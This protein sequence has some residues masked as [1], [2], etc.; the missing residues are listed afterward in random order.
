[1]IDR[2]E[3]D[4]VVIGAGAGGAVAA[5]ELAEG[6]ARVV[7]LEQGPRHDPDEFTA[8]PPEMLARLYRDGGQTVTIGAPPILLPLGRGVGGTTLV[9]P[10]PASARRPPCSTAGAAS[11]GCP[12]TRP[13]WPPCS[14]GSRPRSPSPQ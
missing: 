8:R 2:I 9:T 7:I 3:A 11:S 10:E 6:G 12:W 14:T 5:A 1:M 13:P 4:V